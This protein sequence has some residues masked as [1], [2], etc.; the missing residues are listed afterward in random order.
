[1]TDCTDFNA[2]SLKATKKLRYRPAEVNGSPV[3]VDNVLYR[4]RYE[5]GGKKKTKP[6]L[7][8]PSRDLYVIES[9]ISSKKL[10]KAEKKSLGLVASYEDVNFLLGKIYALK[11]QDALA[12]EHFN[13]FLNVNYDYE[14]NNLRHTLEISAV[15]I[16]VE[17]LFKVEDYSGIIRLAP[18]INNSRII[19]TDNNFQNKNANNL[20]DISYFY[21]GASYVMEDMP[22]EGK[23]ALLFVKKRTKD[24]KFLND[25]NNYLLQAQ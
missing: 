13:R 11:N 25:I 23:E 6:I 3:K 4:F 5:M 18:R 24:K 14:G 15:A 12:I 16:I 22:N 2:S 19:L 17:K 7:N 8:I 1:M 10:D 9:W 20:I 21:L